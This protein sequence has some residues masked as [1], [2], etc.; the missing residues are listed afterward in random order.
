MRFF[1][2]TSSAAPFLCSVR[3]LTVQLS[4]EGFNFCRK[5]DSFFPLI[6]R[7]VWYRA[8]ETEEQDC[9]EPNGPCRGPEVLAHPAVATDVNLTLA[10]VDFEAGEVAELEPSGR[11]GHVR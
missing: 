6:K 2:R 8:R 7:K 4:F 9:G 10:G 11:R 3:Y 1:L 5:Y